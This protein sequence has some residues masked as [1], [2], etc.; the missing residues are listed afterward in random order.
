M[1]SNWVDQQAQVAAKRSGTY[2]VNPDYERRLKVD[3]ERQAR[4]T[5]ASEQTEKTLHHLAGRVEELRARLERVLV[6][7]GSGAN[8]ANGQGNSEAPSSPLTERLKSFRNLAQGSIDIV[9]DILN[10]LDV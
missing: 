7:V 6:P 10:R 5:E 4:S 1:A 3:I 8:L 2:D 9:E